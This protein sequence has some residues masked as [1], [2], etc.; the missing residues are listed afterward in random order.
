MNVFAD[1]H[2]GGLYHSLTL[3]FVKRLGFNLFRPI[4]MEWVNQ[5]IWQYSDNP[6]TQKQYLDPAGCELR[7]DG[8]YYWRDQAEEIDHKCLTFEQFNSMKID[9]IIG[10]CSQ[11][12][13]PF[14][15]LQKR[16]K[17]EAKYIRLTGNSGEPVDWAVSRNIIDTTNLYIAPPGINRVV[18]HQEF[19][20][21]HF[22]YQAPPQVNRIRSYL[23]CMPESPYYS[24]WHD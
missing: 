1:Y 3:Q 2:H 16:F 14:A 24:I 19:P 12:E 23:N 17:P 4:G 13:I 18:I 15:Y 7:P 6:D 21:D 9:L 5:H 8:Y 20:L 22:F 11:H 10:S